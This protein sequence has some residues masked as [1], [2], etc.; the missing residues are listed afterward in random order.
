MVERIP[1]RWPGSC[2][3]LSKHEAEHPASGE[4]VAL[5]AM[6]HLTLRRLGLACD[7]FTHAHQ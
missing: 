5:L 6:T 7:G 4:A 1:F 2:G 3:H